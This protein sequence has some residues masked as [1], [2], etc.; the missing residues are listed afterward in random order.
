MTQ[1]GSLFVNV[2]GILEKMYNIELLSTEFY[3]S[4]D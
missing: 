3:M 2:P 1:L 4:F